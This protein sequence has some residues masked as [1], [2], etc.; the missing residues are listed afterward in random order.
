MQTAPFTLSLS[1]GEEE[2]SCFDELSTNGGNTSVSITYA[3]LNRVWT[4][5]TGRTAG[6]GLAIEEPL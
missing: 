1:K 6:D 3:N 4:G 5:G 2:G